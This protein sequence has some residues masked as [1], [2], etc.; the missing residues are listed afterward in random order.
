[1]LNASVAL[2]GLGRRECSGTAAPSSA[3][4]ASRKRIT[5]KGTKEHKG[6]H[7][8]SQSKGG[9]HRGRRVRTEEH[10]KHGARRKRGKR[11][12]RWAA[13]RGWDTAGASRSGLLGAGYRVPELARE[14]LPAI[15]IGGEHASRV[16]FSGIYVDALASSEGAVGDDVPSVLRDDV[17]SDEIDFAAG[18][19]AVAGALGDDD[20]STTAT[21]DAGF[22][23]NPVEPLGSFAVAG[24]VEGVIFAPGLAND[25]AAGGG[26]EHEAYFRQ[27][28]PRLTMA[29][30]AEF[31]TDKQ[32][33]TP[34]KQF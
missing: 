22:N 15:A 31:H 12:R 17:G 3:F 27:L 23:L 8:E 29:Q 10:R 33:S 32:Y 19:A 16:L 9:S 25:E 6:K 34:V 7:S 5:T 11:L 24:E 4:S 1:M 28:A 20:V 2:E 13:S 21:A 18:V 30:E 14:E 26:H